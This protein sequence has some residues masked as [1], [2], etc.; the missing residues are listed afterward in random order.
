LRNKNTL[1]D[2]ILIPWNEKYRVHNFIHNLLWNEKHPENI[3]KINLNDKEQEELM[4]F[5]V[6]MIKGEL[7]EIPLKDVLN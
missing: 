1:S 5:P 3:K 7:I 6:Y 4:N 2:I